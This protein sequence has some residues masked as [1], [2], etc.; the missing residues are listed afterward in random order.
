MYIKLLLCLPVVISRLA[1]FRLLK[2]LRNPTVS[3]L[4]YILGTGLLIR[5]SSINC[6]VFSVCHSTFEIVIHQ[7]MKQNV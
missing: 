6:T 3:V 7:S 5:I 4:L 2:Q 1:N